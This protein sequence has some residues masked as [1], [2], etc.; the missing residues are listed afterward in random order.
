MLS[1]EAASVTNGC[2]MRESSTGSL[3]RLRFS[4]R[5]S[6]MNGLL[7][8]IGESRKDH[9]CKSQPEDP[10]FTTVLVLEA[11]AL[12][13]SASANPYLVRITLHGKS[14]MSVLLFLGAHRSSF[15]RLG[16]ASAGPDS[17]LFTTVPPCA[18]PFGIL[19]KPQRTARC[20]TQ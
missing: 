4:F 7:H 9:N 11:C 3:W 17:L 10:T 12:A 15:P 13:K 8:W 14:R 2:V 16:P 6:C 18:V 19:S 5:F 1:V 20:A